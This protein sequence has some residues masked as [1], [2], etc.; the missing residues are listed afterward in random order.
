MDAVIYH[1]ISQSSLQEILR[2]GI[3]RASQG[4]KSK[5]SAIQKLDLFL[6]THQ[7]PHLAGTGLSRRNNI[8]GYLGDG[9]KII[10]IIDGE[11]VTIDKFQA[12]SH[13]RIVCLSV[14]PA[15]CYISDLDLYDT[16]KRAMELNEQASTRENLAT[17]YWHKLIP[18]NTFEP[19]MIRRPEVMI[20]HDVAPDCIRIVQ[21]GS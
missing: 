13:K 8:Y 15:K 18:L 17:Q 5:D 12:K 20:T 14:D 10:D 11:R 2:E 4:D 21:G 9:R 16:L 1:E 19:T 7:P 3:K 6:D